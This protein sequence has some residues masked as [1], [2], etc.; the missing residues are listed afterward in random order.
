MNFLKQTEF[1]MKGLNVTI[2]LKFMI[3]IGFVFSSLHFYGQSKKEQIEILNNRMDS[4]NKVIISNRVKYNQR[5]NQFENDILT[6]QKQLNILDS[7]VFKRTRELTIKEE[8]L[9][10]TNI[11]LQNI[12]IEITNLHKQVNSKSELIKDLENQID[13]ITT[14]LE[15]HS[16]NSKNKIENQP[17]NTFSNN[18]TNHVI[19][20]ESVNLIKIGNQTW[21]TEDLSITKY[22]NGDNIPEALNENQWNQYGKSRKGC[23]ARLNNG[24]LLY[25]GYALKDSRGLVPDGFK[26]PTNDDFKILVDFLGGGD[27]QSGIATLAM[28][29]YP[30]FVEEWVGDE[31]TGGLEPVEI[32]SN[33][34]SNFNAKMGGFIYDNGTN[35]QSDWNN[36]NFWWTSTPFEDKLYAF[37]IGHCSQDVGLNM[38]Y[39]LAFG[40]AVRCIKR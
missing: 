17:N 23:F 14:K 27:S 15:E 8:E 7:T 6:L 9:V 35:F 21:M 34:K 32:A 2:V 38:Y 18:S 37:D 40:F 26:I 30:I 24:T 13:K 33:G 31:E 25:N 11:E 36:C 29:T 22:N 4:L 1:S 16:F 19:Q 20:T 12:L 3:H 39:P 10:K 28:V 5:D